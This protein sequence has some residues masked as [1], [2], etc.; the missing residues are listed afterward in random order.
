MFAF[1]YFIKLDSIMKFLVPSWSFVFS[2][3]E[4]LLEFIIYVFTHF[5]LP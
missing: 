5:Y 1:I 2:R 3:I 4:A